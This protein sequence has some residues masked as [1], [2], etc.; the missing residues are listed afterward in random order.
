MA[1]C[2]VYWYNPAT[3]E[4]EMRLAKSLRLEL[5]ETHSGGMSGWRAEADHEV[6]SLRRVAGV[7]GA[8]RYLETIEEASGAIHLIFEYAPLCPSSMGG[9]GHY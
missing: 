3:G 6:A 7:Q 8:V 1:N 5:A 4:L 9:P 2:R